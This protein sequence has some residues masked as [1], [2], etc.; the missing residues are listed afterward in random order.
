VLQA[1]KRP[2]RGLSPQALGVELGAASARLVAVAP[3]RRERDAEIVAGAPGE[4]AGA[5]LD[6]IEGA[7]AGS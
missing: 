3:P 7:L 6:R 2:P 4:I 1:R 5:L